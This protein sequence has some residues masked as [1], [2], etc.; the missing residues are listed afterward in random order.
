M[1]FLSLALPILPLISFAT[2]DLHNFAVCV[3][4]RKYSAI[5]GS[6]FSVSYNY[7]K[8]FELLPEATKC[9]CELYRQRNTGNKQWDSCP[10]CVYDEAGL[11]CGSAGY[12]IGGDEMNHYCTKYCH[13]QGA[14]GSPS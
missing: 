8:D 12:H 4:N 9:A 1:H 10:D 6:P 7:A 3:S 2:A 11:Q 13:A 14:E 5:G